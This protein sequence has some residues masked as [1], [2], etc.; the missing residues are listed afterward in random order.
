MKFIFATTEVHKVPVTILSRVQR[1]DFKLIPAQADRRAPHARARA[2]EKIAPT[3][4]R[5][6][7]DRARGR[8]QHA[9]RDEPARSGDRLGRRREL[10][11]ADVARVLG[12]ASRQVLHDLA[13]ALVDGDAGALPATSSA[14]SRTRATTSPTWRA[15]CSRC[16]AISWSP[17]SAAS[18]AS[19][20]DL[21]DEEAQDVKALAGPQRR[22]R[23]LC[24]CIRAFRRPSTTSSRAG[25][26]APRSRCCW[27]GSR[28]GRRSCRSTTCWGG[29]GRSSAAW[30]AAAARPA[31]TAQGRSRASGPRAHPGDANA[32]TPRVE[33]PPAPAPAETSRAEPAP[34]PAPV[35]RPRAEAPPAPVVD[36]APRPRLVPSEPRAVP[37]EPAPDAAEPVPLDDW[38]KI[39]ELVREERPELAAFLE[40]AAPLEVAPGQLVLGWERGSMFAEEASSKDSMA[41][42]TRAACDHFKT[43]TRVTF[44]ARFS[45]RQERRHRR[46]ARLR[47]QK[48]PCPRGRVPCAPPPAR[49]RRDRDSGREAQG[50]EARGRLRASMLPERV[51]RLMQ[52]LARLP[53][54]G[55]KTAQR[56]ALFLVGDAE[57]SK[58]SP[59]ARRVVE[60]RSD[61]ASAAATSLK[62]TPRD[63]PSARSAA[64]RGAIRS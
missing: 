14:S 46:V 22:R 39:V 15:I 27:C 57:L 54:V 12:V 29:C 2:E 17:R 26:R 60:S 30:A 32:E 1:F 64:T 61:P 23:S 44:R 7:I 24:A 35:E 13:G 51:G 8:G 37:S 3:T 10:S 20:L 52:L 28:A 42:L 36:A 63:T 45:A 25:S 40:H 9:R 53:G 47:G 49:H 16:C 55:E 41:L 62:W 18:P 19:L 5:C 33:A 6:A 31:S 21:A 48:A 4:A 34:A 11:G 56:F 58:R 38:R 50:R 43:R 59:G